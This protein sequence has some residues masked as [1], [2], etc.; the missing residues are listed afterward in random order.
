MSETKPKH[1]AKDRLEI[2]KLVLARICQGLPPEKAAKQA[3]EYADA[4]LTEVEK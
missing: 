3:L 1:N 2:A 4:L